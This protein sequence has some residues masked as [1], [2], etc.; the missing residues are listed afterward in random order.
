MVIDLLFLCA[1]AL[2]LFKGLQRG[3]IVAVFSLVAFIVGLAAAL[4]LSAVAA[5]YLQEH[6]EVSTKWA[7][8]LSFALVFFVVVLLIRIAA[9]LIETTVEIA[10]LGWVNKVGG[11]LLYMVLYTIIL[12]ILLFFAVQLKMISDETLQASICYAFIEPWGPVVMN[13]FGKLIPAFRDLFTELEDFFG[14]LS[15]KIDG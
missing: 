13:G 7:P 2:A 14:N 5:V 9:N 3:L 8:V 1:L 11:V 6:W 4:K 10:W 12:S 15:Q